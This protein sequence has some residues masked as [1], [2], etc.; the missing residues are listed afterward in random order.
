MQTAELV[1]LLYSWITTRAHN[2]PF[3]I[4]DQSERLFSLEQTIHAA[5]SRE[6]TN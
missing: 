6:E 1:S 3:R 5:T 4:Y 2:L